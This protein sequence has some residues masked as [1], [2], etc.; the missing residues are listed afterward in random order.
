MKTYNF[1][2]NQGKT[3]YLNMETTPQGWVLL[4]KYVPEYLNLGYGNPI[5]GSEINSLDANEF[6]VDCQRMIHCFNDNNL[7]YRD[8]QHC[9]AVLNAVVGWHVQN[10]GRIIFG[11][12]MTYVSEMCALMAAMGYGEAVLKTIFPNYVAAAVQIHGDAVK[13][14]LP[15]YGAPRMMNFIGTPRHTRLIQMCPK[16]TTTPK[17]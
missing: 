14:S 12:L 2:L 8:S 17:I 3:L 1:H 16:L 6:E 5:F 9:F 13:E 15:S 11:D 4:N 7:N 10:Y